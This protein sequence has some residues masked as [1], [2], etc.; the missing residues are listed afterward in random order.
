MANR[1]RRKTTARKSASNLAHHILTLATQ[2]TEQVLQVA[3][4]LDALAS[5]DR[6][7]D[8]AIHDDMV[9]HGAPPS[10]ITI[11]Q[12][13]LKTEMRYQLKA[14]ALTIDALYVCAEKAA[15]TPR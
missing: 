7:I 2:A 1:N 9:K 6:T 11:L 3:L 15:T 14:L 13:A 4:T 12:Q 5:M 8:R 10:Q